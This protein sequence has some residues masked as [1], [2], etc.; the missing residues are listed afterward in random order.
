MPKS[1]ERRKFITNRIA[2]RNGHV[3]YQVPI[4]HWSDAHEA[5]AQKYGGELFKRFMAFET[6]VE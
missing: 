1:R 5:V 4:A 3:E 6:P 2:N